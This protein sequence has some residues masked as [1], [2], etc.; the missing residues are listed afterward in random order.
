VPIAYPGVEAEHEV[1]FVCVRACVH[2]RVWAVARLRAVRHILCISRIVYCRYSSPSVHIKQP[3][4]GEWILKSCFCEMSKENCIM[5]HI[6]CRIPRSFCLKAILRCMNEILSKSKNVS[7]N[8]KHISCSFFY[9]VH[10]RIPRRYKY[11][12]T[13]VL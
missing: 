2:T 5:L 11:S 13:S 3:I 7:N 6:A 10:H 9:S 12:A 1:S 8:C 4:Y